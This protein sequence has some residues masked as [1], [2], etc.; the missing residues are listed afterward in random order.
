MNINQKEKNI[1][2]LEYN[3]ILNKQNITMVLIG[4]AFIYVL[5]A[6]SLPDG[7]ARSYLIILLILAWIITL[8]Y[9]NRQLNKI[10]EEIKEL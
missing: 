9:F 8:Q 2:D 1:K 5:F 6:E 3:S 4:T 7:L 10:K